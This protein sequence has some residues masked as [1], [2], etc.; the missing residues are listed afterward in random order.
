MDVMQW[1]VPLA[2]RKDVAVCFAPAWADR[3]PATAGL[4]ALRRRSSPLVSRHLVRPVAVAVAADVVD[5]ESETR[6]PGAPG[7]VAVRVHL[8]AEG[9]PLLDAGA[10]DVGFAALL[11][12]FVGVVV[13][14][15]EAAGLPLMGAMPSDE[16]RAL[17]LLLGG[18]QANP[19][20]RLADSLL[21]FAGAV[22][23]SALA[24]GFSASCSLVVSEKRTVPVDAAIESEL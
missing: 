5:D 4:P 24:R 19:K 11:A 8:S 7:Q 3:M 22:E 16:R 10:T 9:A 17:H 13:D 12:E 23:T 20:S 18:L 14:I 2:N 6:L 15:A 21:L 1:L